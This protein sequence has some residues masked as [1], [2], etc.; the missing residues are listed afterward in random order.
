MDLWDPPSQ[1]VCAAYDG[2]LR[3]VRRLVQQDWRLLDANDWENTPLTAASGQGQVEV[4]R[5][6]LYKGAEVNLPS[7]LGDSALDV[8]CGHGR[9]EAAS[10]LLAHGADPAGAREDDCTPLMRAS[11]FGH[12]DVVVL[13]LAHGCG[14]IDR[15]CIDE[16][17]A[18]H[19]ACGRGHVRVVR[20]L[21]GPGADPH[22]VDRDGE[23]P[24]SRAVRL[25]REECVAM[26]QVCVIDYSDMVGA[27]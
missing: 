19:Y 10:L 2:N 6:L 9:L 12:T 8:A 5:Y 27:S 24:L 17:T 21:L 1:A 3:K 20:A 4:I 22:A 23:T 16:R 18:L 13:L 14:D 15:R 25:G 26:L 7:P 11:A